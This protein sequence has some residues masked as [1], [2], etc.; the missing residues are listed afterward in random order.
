MPVEYGNTCYNITLHKL[1]P[2]V[3]QRLVS[4]LVMIAT[5]INTTLKERFSFLKHFL[6]FFIHLF[7]FRRAPVSIGILLPALSIPV[8]SHGF[9]SIGNY[10]SPGSI[11]S[12][13]NKTM[14]Q[15]LSLRYL[16]SVTI[17]LMVGVSVWGQATI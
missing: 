5:V 14:L 11:N 7:R 6:Y 3:M 16:V 9:E 10:K 17:F 13:K 12:L 8:N 2:L 1:K 4:L 15:K